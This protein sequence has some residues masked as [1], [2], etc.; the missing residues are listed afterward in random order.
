MPWLPLYAYRDD[1]DLIR[2]W[3]NSEDSI[4]YL[5]SSGP[6]QWI[7]KGK[8]D[9]FESTRIGLWHIPSGQLP[10]LAEDSSGEDGA[11]ADPWSGWT[12][13]RT[14][15]N[16]AAPYFGAGHPGV[17]WFNARDGQDVIE[18]SSFEWIG[19]HYRILGNAAHLDTEKWWRRLGRRMKRDAV[20]VPRTGPLDGEKPEIWA[21]PAAL[22]ALGEGITRN[23]N[24]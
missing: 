24:P 13:R 11:V 20:R 19:N 2:E 9:A 14:G 12:E 7:A 10:L 6:K 5:V 16:P 8:L 21:L 17:V 15:A 4:A 22:K 3:L 18:L 1:F 23:R